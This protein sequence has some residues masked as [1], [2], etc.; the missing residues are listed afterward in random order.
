MD[1]RG[2]VASFKEQRNAKTLLKILR[3]DEADATI[4]MKN[5]KDYETFLVVKGELKALEK[6]IDLLT[7]SRP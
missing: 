7:N 2:L 5:A 3:L 4:R 1:R 6:A